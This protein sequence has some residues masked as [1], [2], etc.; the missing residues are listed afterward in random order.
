[1]D[2]LLNELS[3]WYVTEELLRL[4]IEWHRNRQNA[5]ITQQARDTNAIDLANLLRLAEQRGYDIK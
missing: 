4:S 3:G 2:Q 1:M 5:L